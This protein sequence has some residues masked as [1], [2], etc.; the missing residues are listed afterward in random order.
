MRYAIS[1]QRVFLPLDI[2]L[3]NLEMLDLVKK[4]KKFRKVKV[5]SKNGETVLPAVE[6][7]TLRELLDYTGLEKSDLDEMIKYGFLQSD[8]VG[9]Y[10]VCAISTHRFNS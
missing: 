3:S 4:L 1:A 9:R 5:V 7:V 6:Y 8:V 2:I 10:P